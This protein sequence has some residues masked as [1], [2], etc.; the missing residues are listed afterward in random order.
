MLRSSLWFDLR[1]D[2]SLYL[3]TLPQVTAVSRQP[4]KDNPCAVRSDALA[5]KQEY[6]AVLSGFVGDVKD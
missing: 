3:R 5:V 1:L 6:M 4:Q 2:G